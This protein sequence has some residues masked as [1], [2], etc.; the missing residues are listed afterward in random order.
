HLR[1]VGSLARPSNAQSHAAHPAVVVPTRIHDDEPPGARHGRS[2][3]ARERLSRG[4]RP[5]L[6]VVVVLR[7]TERDQSR[8]RENVDAIHVGAFVVLSLALEM[9]Q[10]DLPPR[11]HVL[12]ANVEL[13]DVL[14]SEI[15]RDLEGRDRAQGV[16]RK[17]DFEPSIASLAVAATVQRA[18]RNRP[19]FG[20]AHD[21][22]ARHAAADTGGTLVRF[23]ARVPVVARD[24]VVE[25]RS[26][27]RPGRRIASA[28][29]ARSRSI[30]LARVVNAN[31][32]RGETIDGA[33]IAIV[34]IRRGGTAG[35]QGGTTVSTGPRG[36]RLGTTAALA[37][38]L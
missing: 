35:T 2:R 8:V 25:E 4:V 24:P 38:S 1:R 17:L 33:R 3:E 32:A 7:R 12:E 19:A 22:V 9:E 11:F 15:E 5:G 16:R 31:A 28:R 29:R 18:V 23:R 20:V 21:D 37:P 27:A 14:V 30:A 10:H 36:A 34:A 26:D 6:D 13:G